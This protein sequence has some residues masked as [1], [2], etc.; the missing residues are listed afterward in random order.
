MDN[1]IVEKFEYA[2]SGVNHPIEMER[3]K[4]IAL[5]KSLEAINSSICYLI[6]AVENLNT[7]IS[8]RR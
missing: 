4:T 7:T 2:V 1:T 6:T 3:Q 8:Q 5:L